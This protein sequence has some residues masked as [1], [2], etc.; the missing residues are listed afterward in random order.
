VIAVRR[1]A[2][3]SFDVLSSLG[4]S[5]VLLLLLGLLTFLGT[6]DQVDHGLYDT[7]RKYFESFFLLHDFGPFALPLPGANLVLCVLAVN[8]VLGGVVRIRKSAATA[9][10]LIVHAGI[11]LMLGAGFVKMYHSEDGHVTLREGQRADSFRSYFEVELVVH[12][13]LRNGRVREHRV[14]QEQFAHATPAAPVRLTSAS[15]PFDVEV[16]HFLRNC[17]PLQKGP[18]FDV[19]VPV[20]DGVFL[21]A[22]APEK[23]AE[24]NLAGAYVSIV[25]R[26][27]ARQSGLLW[28][29]EDR[30]W[31]FTVD[32]RRFVVQ[33]TMKSF[34]LGFTLA[35]A[36][37]RKIDHP[38]MGLA[39][40]F[41]SDVQVLDDASSRE[42]TIS[43]NEPLRHGGLVVYQSGWGP[44]D[45]R[46][47]PPWSTFS[48]VRNPADQ[49]PLVSCIVI[50]VGLIVHFSRKLFGFAKHQARTA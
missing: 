29:P 42:L 3:R 8:L 45:G 11:L 31:A 12:E 6:L 44:Q 10:I 26:Q 49:I 16:S 47:I 15:L 17:T 32:E 27:G 46:R 14:P 22:L 21:R 4:L 2:R 25:P 33:L 24:A 39:K 43:M 5:C 41:E 48:V 13:D 35:L 18:M 38:G 23:E 37:F 9:G 19:D 50:S 34:P 40:S 30:G 36:D 20:I 28:T 7:Q 1:L